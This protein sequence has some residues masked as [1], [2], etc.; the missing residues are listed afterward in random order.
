MGSLETE[1]EAMLTALFF[2]GMKLYE[3]DLLE[4]IF[5]FGGIAPAGD[6]NIPPPVFSPSS[7]GS[8]NSI[9]LPTRI[10]LRTNRVMLKSSEL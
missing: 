3:D 6:V 9:Q 2:E 10:E 4:D 7:V 1:A 8:N 5:D